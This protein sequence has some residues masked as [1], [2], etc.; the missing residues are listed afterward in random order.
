MPAIA[1]AGG[2]ILVS[3]PAGRQAFDLPENRFELS[4]THSVER[5]EWR[6]TFSVD[7]SGAI[8][9]VSS[10]FE[11]AGAGLPGM[12]NAGEVVR[13][14]EGKMRLTGSRLVVGDLRVQLSDLSR[15]YLHAEG[16]VID[17]NALFG[18]GIIT[19]RVE[20]SQRREHDEKS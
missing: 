1:Q 19:I 14:A 2:R 10:E 4:W 15:H 9:L 5:T 17:L 6:E 7:P 3:G 13:L 12:P 16:R 18:E 8:S 20:T 11:S